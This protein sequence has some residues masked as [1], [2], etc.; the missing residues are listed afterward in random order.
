[1]SHQQFN[2]AFQLQSFQVQQYFWVTFVFKLILQHYHSNRG[3]LTHLQPSQGSQGL[4]RSEKTSFVAIEVKSSK[5]PILVK[6]RID[7]FI[8][9]SNWLH[10]VIEIYYISVI[11]H[12]FWSSFRHFIRMLCQTCLVEKFL[13]T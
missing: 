9:T 11:F 5:I 3:Q 6:H 12:V 8:L 1:M 2:L 7:S 13:R 4:V 10:N